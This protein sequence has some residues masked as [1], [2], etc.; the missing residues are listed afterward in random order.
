MQL[1]VSMGLSFWAGLQIDTYLAM[2]LPIAAWL[3]PLGI[4]LSNMYALIK[5]TVN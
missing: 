2:C 3:L 5:Q 1:L 4:F